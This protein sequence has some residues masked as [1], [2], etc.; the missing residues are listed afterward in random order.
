MILRKYKKYVNPRDLSN[1]HCIFKEK[2]LSFIDLDK[3]VHKFDMEED[4]DKPINWS[5]YLQNSQ[6]MKRLP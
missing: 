4:W 2:E 1:H 5:N 3:F 6:I